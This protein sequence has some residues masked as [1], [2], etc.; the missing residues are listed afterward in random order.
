MGMYSNVVKPGVKQCFQ[1]KSTIVVAVLAII[2]I[3][4]REAY[5]A[6][7]DGGGGGQAAQNQARLKQ[8]Y[9]NGRYDPSIVTRFTSTALQPSSHTPADPSTKTSTQL[10]VNEGVMKR[11]L[12]SS[13]QAGGAP[14]VLQFAE[15]NLDPGASTDRNRHRDATEIFHVLEGSAIIFVGGRQE[16]DDDS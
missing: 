5:H 13:S 15:A 3:I 10:P 7:Q 16:G 9:P 11:V 1:T 14:N 4:W 2:I 6:G 12:V 8:L